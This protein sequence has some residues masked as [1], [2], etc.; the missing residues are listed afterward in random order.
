MPTAFVTKPGYPRALMGTPPS[1]AKPPPK[2]SDSDSSAPIPGWDDDDFLSVVEE[3]SRVGALPT[4][5]P[6]PGGDAIWRGGFY[7]FRNGRYLWIRGAWVNPPRSGL[8]WVPGF[9]QKTPQGGMFIN[10]HWRKS[11]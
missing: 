4:K 1:G 8:T 7:Q 9:Y 10:G 6:D 2:L 11:S 5:P 3:A